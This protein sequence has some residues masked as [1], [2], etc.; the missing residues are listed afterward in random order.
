MPGVSTAISQGGSIATNVAAPAPLLVVGALHLDLVGHLHGPHRPAASNPVRFS[1]GPGG[2]GANVA[3]AIAA[4]GVPCH[5]VC[6]AGTGPVDPSLNLPDIGITRV[7]IDGHAPGRYVAILDPHGELVS[8]Y[9]DTLACEHASAEALL[10]SMPALDAAALVVEANLSAEALAGLVGA[11]RLSVA[12]LAVSPH[13]ALRLKP[14]AAG[15]A[16]LLCNRREAVSLTGLA[17]NASL[18]ALADALHVSRF[19]RVV[20]TDGPAGILVAEPDRR[21]RLPAPEIGPDGVGSVNGAGDALAGATLAALAAQAAQAAQAT[22]ARPGTSNRELHTLLDVMNARSDRAPS[23]S[24]SP[25]A[26]AVA[27]PG[28]RAALNVLR[29]R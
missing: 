16:L 9:S 10:R 3:R 21:C 6:P 15:I 26:E 29:A 27:G 18:E 19:A 4:H 25:L 23:G 24:D 22:S 8:G 14:I 20:L 12:A 1:A 2:V 13:K 5:L 28:R 11:S 7:T 17:P